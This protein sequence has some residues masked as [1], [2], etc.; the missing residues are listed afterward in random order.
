LCNFLWRRHGSIEKNKHFLQLHILTFPSG[1]CG[2]RICW[3]KVGGEG[4]GLRVTRWVCEKFA[5]NVANHIFCQNYDVTFYAEKVSKTV[6]L[7]L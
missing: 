1:A 7:L 2:K 4:V 3:A 6:W 5:L